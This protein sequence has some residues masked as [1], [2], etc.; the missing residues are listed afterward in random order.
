LDQSRFVN[1]VYDVLFVGGGPAGTGPLVAAARRGA[2]GDLLDRGIA[3]IERGPTLGGGSI[4]RYGIK[5]STSSGVFLECLNAADGRNVLAGVVDASSTQTLAALG[6][7]SAPLT[8]VGSYLETLGETLCRHLDRPPTS[9]VMTHTE[10]L[11]LRRTNE[12][13][14]EVTARR[15]PNGCARE[16]MLRLRARSVVLALGGWQDRAA[17]LQTEIV[18][19][20]DLTGPLEEKVMLSDAAL[21]PAGLATIGARLAGEPSPKVVIVGGSHSAFSVAWSLLYLLSGVSFDEGAITILHRSPI[22]PFYPSRDEAKRD[23]YFDFDDGDICPLT[24]RVH[25][26]GGLRSEERDL[27]R[28]VMGLGGSK[29]E[30]RVRL[31]RIGHDV[32]REEVA[33]L[34]DEA[35]LIL[36]AYGYHPVTIPVSSENGRELSLRG[37][38]GKPFVDER[39]R[40]V[41]A[42]GSVVPDLFAT[43]LGA[44]F[45]PPGEPNF[46]GQATGIWLYQHHVGDLI[47]NEL[48]RRPRV[49]RRR[50]PGPVRLPA[51]LRA[52][53]A[54]LC[55]SGIQVE[56]GAP[57]AGGVGAWIDSV[58]RRSY[59]YS[60]ITGYFMTFAVRLAALQS[61]ARWLERAERAARWIVDCAQDPSG[62]VLCRKGHAVDG[63]SATFAFEGGHTWLFDCAMV[64]YGL[65]TTWRATGNSQWLD[66][67]ERI[68]GFVRGIFHRLDEADAAAFDLT[69]NEIVPPGPRWSR[70]LGPFELKCV[71]F[72]DSLHRIT[73]ESAYRD[74]VNRLLERTLAT[75][76]PS[77]RFGTDREGFTTHLHPHFY[78]VEGLLYLASGGER[79]DLLDRAEAAIDWAFSECLRPGALVQAWSSH[80]ASVISGIRTDILAQALRAHE[81]VRALRPARHGRPWEGNLPALRELLDRHITPD[82]G[83]RYGTDENGT[84]EDANA[85]CQFFTLEAELARFSPRHAVPR[86]PSEKIVL[87]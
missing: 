48:L 18:D 15:P 81:I 74:L 23:G 57:D 36:P 12:D 83:I 14:W 3:V 19:G 63:V 11:G 7:S 56:E 76:H 75:Q 41:E 84:H 6:Q 68:G 5:S 4:G 72:L 21:Q 9:A 54:W 38:P 1:G 24:G 60:E 28:H 69:T 34:L 17:A 33:A 58:G 43:G 29:R 46:S 61:D 70:H 71:L 67:A 30:R 47:L 26:L 35:A 51:S 32:S 65:L 78:A 55:D 64:G 82:G 16:A 39:C 87:T 45:R 25:R 66:A 80:P 77:G 49:G 52:R 20:I 62:A 73:G 59:L 27:H 79:P 42:D 22:R 85:W 31:L 86:C 13:G 44:G 50:V 2:L 53:C 37:K 10:A 40:V 8:L